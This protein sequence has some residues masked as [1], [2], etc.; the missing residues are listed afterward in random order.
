MCI[1]DRV[2]ANTTVQKE[3]SPSILF[4]SGSHSNGQKT[5]LLQAGAPDY[6]F[7]I[8][9]TSAAD[10]K[11]LNDKQ[12]V[13]QNH[14]LIIFDGVSSRDNATSFTDLLHLIKKYLYLFL[15]ILLK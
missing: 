13:F 10:I 1:R 9:T 11:K 3:L 12:T 2:F 8:A 4:V 5:A 15:Y 14:S 6:G 7:T